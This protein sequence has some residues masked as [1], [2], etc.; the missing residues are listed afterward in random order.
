MHTY[1]EIS[2]VYPR[3]VPSGCTWGHRQLRVLAAPQ[4][5]SSGRGSWIPSESGNI[6]PWHRA[7]NRCCVQLCGPS[8]G[9]SSTTV[10]MNLGTSSQDPSPSCVNLGSGGGGWTKF[11]SLTVVLALKCYSSTTYW[12]RMSSVL[13]EESYIKIRAQT[14]KLYRTILVIFGK[15]LDF[16]KLSLCYTSK[17]NGDNSTQLKGL[18]GEMTLWIQSLQNSALYILWV[19]KY[20]LVMSNIF[21]FFRNIL[22]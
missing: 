7:E 9:L 22:S 20:L 16:C 12:L 4:L 21:I 19:S 18:L 8:M 3:V 2:E 10:C 6:V 15:L 13:D 1:L 17:G 5:S 11:W 14:L